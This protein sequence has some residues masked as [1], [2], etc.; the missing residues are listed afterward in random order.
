M[1]EFEEL[2][3][4]KWGLLLQKL[5]QARKLKDGFVLCKWQ[6]RQSIIEFEFWSFRTLSKKS[7]EK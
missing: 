7:A 3:L 5:G 1:A 2:L 4:Q 6:G